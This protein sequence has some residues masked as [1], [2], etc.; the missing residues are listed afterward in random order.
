MLYFSLHELLRFHS[1]M[2]ASKPT[3]EGLLRDQHS[4]EELAAAQCSRQR[5]RRTGSTGHTAGPG[6]AAAAAAAAGA[7]RQPQHSG[8]PPYSSLLWCE[9]LVEQSRLRLSSVLC[10]DMFGGGSS[11]G[12]TAMQVSVL[13]HAASWEVKQYPEPD[14]ARSNSSSSS[15]SSWTAPGIPGRLWLPGMG[16]FHSITSAQWFFVF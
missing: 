5:Q 15:N 7:D 10:A 3:Y 2:A 6:N 11:G 4:D 14:A 12:S 8:H 9:A 13:V 16:T 1:W